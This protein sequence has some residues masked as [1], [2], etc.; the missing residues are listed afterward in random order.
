MQQ[1]QT[2]SPHEQA[3]NHTKT[4]VNNNMKAV[5]STLSVIIIWLS[6]LMLVPLVSLKGANGFLAAPNTV[7][8]VVPNH[9]HSSGREGGRLFQSSRAETIESILLEKK[10]TTFPPSFPPFFPQRQR[11]RHNNNKSATVS[12][13]SNA[14][15]V[16]VVSVGDVFEYLFS[17]TVPFIFTSLQQVGQNALFRIKTVWTQVWWLFPLTLCLVPIYTTLCWQSTPSTPEFWKLVDTRHIGFHNMLSFL[18]SNI[19]YFVSGT[20]MVLWMKQPSPQIRTSHVRKLGLW[21]LLAGSVST[22][23][24]TVQSLGEYS[25]AEALCYLDHGIAGTAVLYFWRRCGRPSITTFLLGMVGLA[26][27]ACP[28]WYTLSHSLWHWVSAAVTICWVRDGIQQQ[29][30]HHYQQQQNGGGTPESPS[31]QPHQPSPPVVV[32]TEWRP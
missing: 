7:F 30:H 17:T 31:L 13:H 19:S 10:T 27:L 14:Q 20:W 3:S 1:I 9:R 4:H 21:V 12:P 22:L 29:H 11:R 15:S 32:V 16:V 23:Y 25:V 26:L 18:S 2:P 5:N 24:H 8:A 6:W 28:W